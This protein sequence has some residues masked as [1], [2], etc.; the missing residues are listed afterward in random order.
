M[1]SGGMVYVPSSMT[2]GSG[3]SV[4]LR[5]LPQKVWDAVMSVLPI[6]GIYK[7]AV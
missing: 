3:I 5:L 4:T 7:Y 1:D 2:I 6:E